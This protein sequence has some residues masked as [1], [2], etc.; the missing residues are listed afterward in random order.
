MWGGSNVPPSRPLRTG[1]RIGIRLVPVGHP[2]GASRSGSGGREE[3]QAARVTGCTD[4]VRQRV[5]VLPVEPHREVHGGIVM[6][7]SSHPDDRSR[8]NFEAFPHENL[9]K[10]GDGRSHSTP[11]V[12]RHRP[13]AGHDPGESNRPLSAGA[14]GAAI[15]SRKVDSPMPSEPPDRSEL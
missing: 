11:V 10:E 12:D 8:L 6:G 2:P 14:D 15:G 13:H 9:G 5:D 4:H 1:T 7:G 3:I